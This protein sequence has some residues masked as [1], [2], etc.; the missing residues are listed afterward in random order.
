ME[1]VLDMRGFRR[2]ILEKRIHI[3]PGF[4]FY[5]DRESFP[6]VCSM[7]ECKVCAPIQPLEKGT[8]LRF[9][10]FICFGCIRHEQTVIDNQ[11]HFRSEELQAIFFFKDLGSCQASADCLRN[12]LLRRTLHFGL[13]VIE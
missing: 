8:E 7:V 1:E 6:A 3:E 2:E 13:A 12:F 11:L 10:S 4:H 9:K 5:M